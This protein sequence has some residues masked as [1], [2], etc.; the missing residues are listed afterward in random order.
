M[1]G[2]SIGSRIQGCAIVVV[3]TVA[4]VIA[5]VLVLFTLLPLTSYLPRAVDQSAREQVRDAVSR[6]AEAYG[7]LA[8]SSSAR[9]LREIL[10]SGGSELGTSVVGQSI[11]Q[12]DS[13]EFLAAEPVVYAIDVDELSITVI[14]LG[15][16]QDLGFGSG[17]ASAYGC[18]NLT[19]RPGS[20]K[21]DIS[22]VECEEPVISGIAVHW[23]DHVD[24]T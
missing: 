20:T 15:H 18:A 17:S 9:E 14:A 13:Q 22:N 23:G 19:A 11:V 4:V 24:A 7:L 3:G 8:L 10:E 12:L 6:G 5:V 21:V 1:S 16:A 2:A